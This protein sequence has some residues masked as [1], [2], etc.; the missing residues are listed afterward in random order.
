MTVLIPAVPEFD[1]LSVYWR[2]A[3]FLTTGPLF[4]TMSLSNG[5]VTVLGVQ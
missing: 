5:L 3:E 1:G 2:T 4:G